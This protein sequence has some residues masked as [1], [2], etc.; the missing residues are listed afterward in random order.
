M[1]VVN[2]YSTYTNCKLEASL[3]KFLNI[4]TNKS[5]KMSFQRIHSTKPLEQ[6]FQATTKPPNILLIIPKSECVAG[7][8]KNTRDLVIKTSFLYIWEIHS[9][10]FIAQQS[11]NST[12]LPVDCGNVFSNNLSH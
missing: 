2:T 4:L 5:L 3:F 7:N 8:N 12:K 1:F 10:L 6:P 11:K 9:A